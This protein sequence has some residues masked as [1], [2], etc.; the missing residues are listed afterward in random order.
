MSEQ[1]FMICYSVFVGLLLCGC[2]YAEYLGAKARAFSDTPEAKEQDRQ[3]ESK[4]RELHELIRR[5]P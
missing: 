5:K 1:A 3:Y 4:L 2:A